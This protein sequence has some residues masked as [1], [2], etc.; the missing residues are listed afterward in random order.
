MK[1]AEHE[2]QTDEADIYSENSREELVADGEMSPEEEGFMAG[3]E[4]D[5]NSISCAD[6][7]KI[8]IDP[9]DAIEAVVDNETLLFC[10]DECYTN[11][12]HRHEVEE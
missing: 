11:Y 6:C 5:E 1:M 3:F 12:K 8:I 10:S 2:E 4:G 7:K 9:D